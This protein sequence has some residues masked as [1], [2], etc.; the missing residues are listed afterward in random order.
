MSITQAICIFVDAVPPAYI[1]EHELL[2]LFFFFFFFHP[3]SKIRAEPNILIA[4][5]SNTIFLV[6]LLVAWIF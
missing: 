3:A 2:L 4:R 6:K 5:Y 1:Y